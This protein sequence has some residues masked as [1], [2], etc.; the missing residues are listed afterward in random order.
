MLAGGVVDG[1]I[2][3]QLDVA[4]LAEV[5]QFFQIRFLTETPIDFIVI[6]RI[7]FMVGGRG[8]DGGEPDALDAQTVL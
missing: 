2:Q 7:I 3:D 1:Q 4:L 5:G 6:R 8:E